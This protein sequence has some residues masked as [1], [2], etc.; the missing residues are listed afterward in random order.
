MK[1]HQ[2]LPNKSLINSLSMCSLLLS[3]RAVRR[4]IRNSSLQII[5]S[6]LGK[7]CKK[8]VTTI[9]QSLLS[10]LFL[11]LGTITIIMASYAFSH[12]LK[13]QFI[14]PKQKIDLCSAFFSKKLFLPTYEFS[15]IFCFGL[16][17]LCCSICQ[18]WTLLKNL[19]VQS[20]ATTNIFLT[21]SNMVYMRTGCS[22]LLRLACQPNS[23]TFCR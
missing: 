23:S 5:S 15:S 16:R 18:S 9:F 4:K 7:G 21:T 2:R 1:K 8:Q 22:C 12:G 11:F 14:W 6:L 13:Q 19:K 20:W 3:R 17:P 10:V